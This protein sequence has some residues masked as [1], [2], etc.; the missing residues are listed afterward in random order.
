[1]VVRKVFVAVKRSKRLPFGGERADDAEV[2]AFAIRL[3]D[4]AMLARTRH[5]IGMTT[6]AR[7]V[8]EKV[9]TDLSEGSGGLHGAVTARAEA[10]VIRLALVYCL[11]DGVDAIDTP[12]LLAALAVWEYC[13]ATARHVFGASLGDRTAD[14][15]A[16]RLDSAG[17]DGLTRTDIPDL[18]GRHLTA[19]RIGA[20]LELLRRKGRA[21]REPVVT[22]VARLNCGERRNERTHLRHKRPKRPKG[23]A[24]GTYVAYVA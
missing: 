10:Q 11:L 21:T 2:E 17:A 15:I 8:W 16:R 4:L 22:G 20:A 6:D 9:Y 12:H 1:L 23:K 7:I 14:E 5:R 24:A 3:C 13:N 19:E 18:F